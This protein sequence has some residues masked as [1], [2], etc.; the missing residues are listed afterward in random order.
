MGG[1]HY[2]FYVAVCYYSAGIVGLMLYMCRN[3]AL[4]VFTCCLS[5]LVSGLEHSVGL[6]GRKFRW[7]EPVQSA[8]WLCG[9]SCLPSVLRL[10]GQWICWLYGGVR[11]H[12]GITR[13][14]SD[15]CWQLKQMSLTRNGRWS[16]YSHLIINWLLEWMLFRY[17][18]KLLGSY[19]PCGQMTRVFSAYLNQHVGCMATE[20]RDHVLKCFVW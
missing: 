19:G 15:S 7:G 5:L 3:T 9:R 11:W 10:R 17:H 2:G 16:P 20:S 4:I 8:G 1:V 18:W 13:S 14:V 6:P 12:S